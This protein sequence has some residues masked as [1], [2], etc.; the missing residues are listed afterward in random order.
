[1]NCNATGAVAELATFDGATVYGSKLDRTVLITSQWRD[2]RVSSTSFE[3]ANLGN[4]VLDRAQFTDCDFRGARLGPASENPPP[5]MRGAVFVD[6]DFSGADFTRASIAG[7]TFKGCKFA[8]ARGEPKWIDNVTITDADIG[9]RKR[10]LDTLA[11]T[12]TV[13][14]V[15]QH[16]G[17]LVAARDAADS[18]HLAVFLVD[19]R[20]QPLTRVPANGA[21]DRLR[22]GSTYGR[23]GI[24]WTIDDLG[25]TV[26]D[27][28][29]KAM[30]V[31]GNVITWPGGPI[32]RAT[33][34]RIGSFVN[35]ESLG[36]RGVKLV[37]PSLSYG[38]IVVVQENDF[39]A[40]DNPSYTRADAR[41][42]GEW[43]LHLG[44][45]L[46]KWLGLPHDNE[47]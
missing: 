8:G 20:A 42:D 40:D 37:I 18:A 4:A 17:P 9:D 36:N 45:D 14:A 47:L 19:E 29:K 38:R 44:R 6:C 15:L 7:A 28:E 33:V 1:M 32:D 34:T 41:R 27:F 26:W 30:E 24:V 23:S 13:D 35:P 2:A 46:A 31:R 12:M 16:P 21:L 43:A 3:N 5:S 25:F 10:V 22:K 11:E 39:A